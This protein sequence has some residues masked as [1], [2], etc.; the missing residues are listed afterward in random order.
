MK[1][2]YDPNMV[3]WASPGINAEMMKIKQGRLCNFTAEVGIKDGTTFA[4]AK[5]KNISSN[6]VTSSNEMFGGL[7]KW[8]AWPGW[9]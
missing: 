3:F 1:F 4:L 8:V 6:L 5:R 9:G 7:E 2:I